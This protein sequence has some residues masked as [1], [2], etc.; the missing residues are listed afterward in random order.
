LTA[1]FISPPSAL[2]TAVVTETFFKREGGRSMGV[3]AL[4]VTIGIPIAPVI[5]GFVA[6]R[7]DIGG[8]IG[9]WPL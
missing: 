5:F 8:Y 6:Q 1:F 3:W 4:M 7:V 2:G 9:L